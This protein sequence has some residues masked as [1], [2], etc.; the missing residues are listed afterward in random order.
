ML[1][2]T[3]HLPKLLLLWAL[4][5]AA[6]LTGQD[7]LLQ[8][9]YWDFPKPGCNGQPTNSSTW[10]ARLNNQAQS[11]QLDAF[12][13]VWLPPFSRASFGSCSNGYDPQDLYDLGEFGGGRTGFGT[14]AEVDQL[15]S[16]FQGKN[17]HAVA[18][19]VYNHRDGG[20]WEDNPAARDY[21][22][23]Y[24]TGAGCGGSP[25]TPY[26]V[27]GKLRYRLPLGGS[28][29][30]G[31]GDYYFKFSSA[32][33]NPGFNGR[34][35][36][37]Y[38]RTQNTP[39]NPSPI[40]EA[41][42][43]GGGDCGQPYN[44]IFLGRDIIATQEVGQGCNTDEFYLALGSSDFNAAGDNLEVYIEEIDGGGT[45]IDQRIYGIWS[46]ARQADIIADLK[47][48]TRTDFQNLP[49]GQGAMNYLN[50]KPNGIHPTC[51]TGDE[52]YPFF[53]F[54]VEQA[55]PSTRT[56]YSSWNQWLWQDAG[57][58]GFRLDAVKHFP[59]W[60][61]GQ[62]LDDLH[63]AGIHPPLVVGEHFTGD[64]GV[65]KGWTEAVSNSMSPAANS[66]IQVRAFDFHLR[67]ALKRATELN[68]DVRDVF[69]AGMVH[70]AGASPFS[71]VTFLNNHDFRT[72]G[73]YIAEPL[74]AYV[75]L[76]TNN[77]IGLPSVF[78]PDYFGTNLG[79]AAPPVLK[80][81]IDA[82]IELHRQHIFGAGDVRYLN[83]RA[84]TRQRL[85]LS[86]FNE[87][88]LFYQIQGGPE[89]K[90]VLVAINFAQIPL[91]WDHQVDA[92][93]GT[94]FAKTLGTTNGTELL[95]VAASSPGGVPNYV[96]MDIPARSYAVFVESDATTHTEPLAASQS[97]RL[98]AFPN[99]A[100]EEVLLQWEARRAQPA[101][102][103]A[104]SALGKRVLL[105]HLEN[106]VGRN[107]FRLDVSAWPAGT[108]FLQLRDAAGDAWVERV[109][110]SSR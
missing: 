21:V 92:P 26:P 51:M 88:V 96:Y 60:F 22:L 31:A 99:P 28:N 36:K 74:L 105:Q 79:Y 91:R 25:A 30:N 75:Y 40:N 7:F 24:P 16:T 38:F 84:S 55:Q 87:N 50:F 54:D 86:G 20:A 66:A 8:G 103:S 32:S 41:E 37:L 76:L 57:I 80:P 110:R 72:A 47:V 27:N 85:V 53:F 61:V 23:N 12:T 65:L 34:R 100:Q 78:Y 83:S 68:M 45:G 46:D 33:A 13:F 82:L 62:L 48:Q 42:P 39:H 19:V 18:D 71:V 101:Q 59:A 2:R 10:A 94:A 108:Y 14:R 107:E 43:N 4:L 106:A 44:Q 11:G 17:I 90:R 109:V 69:T 98:L 102:L 89:G 58:R 3:H 35:Y 95:T 1:T 70:G 63:A 29:G 5:A 97:S 6:S 67:D 49:S 52:E 93:V 15:I 73:E 64:A 77:Q 56:A 104:Y 81:Q 9:W